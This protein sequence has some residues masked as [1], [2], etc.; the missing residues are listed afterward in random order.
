MEDV[1]SE[2]QKYRR[3][4]QEQAAEAADWKLQVMVLRRDNK[5]LRRRLDRVYR[6]WT[7][8]VGRMVLFPYYVAEWIVDKLLRRSRIS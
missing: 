7:W 1:E 4:A 5:R 3:F 6:S 8:R 2:L